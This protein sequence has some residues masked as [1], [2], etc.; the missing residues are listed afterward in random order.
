M[1][2]SCGR[3]FGCQSLRCDP[4]T[5]V[6]RPHALSHARC[7]RYDLT[8]SRHWQVPVGSCR[9]WRQIR[10]REIRQHS[11]PMPPASIPLFAHC[12]CVHWPMPGTDKCRLAARCLRFRSG[13]SKRSGSTHFRCL[14][15]RFLRS[16]IV[17]VF[18]RS[19][20][21]HSFVDC[22][23][24]FV[25]TAVTFIHSL[26]QY[27]FARCCSIHLLPAAHYDILIAVASVF[28][29]LR[30]SLAHCCSICIAHWRV[31]Q[32]IR[33]QEIRQHS[34][35]IPPASIPS[36]AHCCSVHSLTVAVFIRSLLQHSFVHCCSIF[37][38]TAATF[39]CS[40]LL[41]YPFAHS[42]SIFFL[43]AAAFIRSLLQ[44]PFTHYPIIH[45]F[46]ATVSIRSLSIR[47]LLLQYPFAHCWYSIH[48]L[49]AAH[50]DILVAG[51]SV[52]LLS[53]CSLA[54]CCSIYIAHWRV[55]QQIRYATVSIRSP[56][57]HHIVM[58]SMGNT[59]MRTDR[60]DRYRD[61][62]WQL[63]TVMTS[64]SYYRCSSDIWQ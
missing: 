31:L 8:V 49:T 59:I 28:L 51:A 50:D 11:F 2:N 64:G 55:L 54:H 42:C 35:P 15:H 21:Q 6:W 58:T 10:Q 9:Y 60:F 25:F 52:F 48:S 1:V 18:I 40:L 14:Q 44:Y 29:L 45:S 4:K 53:R 43:T 36:F 20:L 19:P 34:V 3:T 63:Q 46:T 37:V 30:Y 62:S 47:S 26:L 16:L 32:Q 33:Q 17:A 38:F 22:C 61:D 56:S 41:Q 57:Q 39:I 5:K 23:S 13:S 12:C 27:L 24:I 7:E